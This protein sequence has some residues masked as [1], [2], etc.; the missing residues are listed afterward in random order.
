MVVVVWS[1][2]I[3][4]HGGTFSAP[5]WHVHRSQVVITSLVSRECTNWSPVA[6]GGVCSDP[7]KIAD[8][9]KAYEF[10]DP[11]MLQLVN[12]QSVDT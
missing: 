12:M 8:N 5:E 2:G 9:R 10:P 7:E 3:E 11:S 4:R 1:P 6:A